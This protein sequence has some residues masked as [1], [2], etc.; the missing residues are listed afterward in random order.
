MKSVNTE[1]VKQQSV[2]NLPQASIVMYMYMCVC[3]IIFECNA[4]AST[5]TYVL[6]AIYLHGTACVYTHITLSELDVIYLVGWSSS[7]T[8]ILPSTILTGSLCPS[9]K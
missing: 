9:M 2:S 3:I 8:T 1:K 7:S 5:L 4:L 6:S